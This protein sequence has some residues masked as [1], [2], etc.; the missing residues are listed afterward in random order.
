MSK[1]VTK[2][3]KTS[4]DN[5]DS[6]HQ[7]NW[8]AVVLIT[9]AITGLCFLLGFVIYLFSNEIKVG[10]SLELFK[11]IAIGMGITPLAGKIWGTIMKC[12]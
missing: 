11:G 3:P 6:K 12:I 1:G 10:V 4:R 8:G 2:P 7:N 9:V 5:Y